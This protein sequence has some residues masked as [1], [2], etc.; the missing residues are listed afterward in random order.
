MSEL[1]ITITVKPAA[2]V[3]IHTHS[4]DLS[5]DA[6]EAYLNRALES[7]TTEVKEFASCPIH[8]SMRGYD[9]RR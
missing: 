2:D 1:V 4:T 9:E 3:S 5:V 6:I 8:K 7:L